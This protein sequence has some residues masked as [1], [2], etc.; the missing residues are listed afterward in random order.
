MVSNHWVGTT[1]DLYS[2]LS[3]AEL[4]LVSE[5][6]RQAH[7]TTNGSARRKLP[8]HSVP[9]PYGCLIVVPLEI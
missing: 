1:I 2:L 4:S 9:S 5:T 7:N 8:D 3:D 6:I